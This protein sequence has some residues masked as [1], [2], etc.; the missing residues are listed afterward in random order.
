M[1]R[2]LEPIV[3]STSRVGFSFSLYLDNVSDEIVLVFNLP[4]A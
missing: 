2:L 4:H 3:F 1:I